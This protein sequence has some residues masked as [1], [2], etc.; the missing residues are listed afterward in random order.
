MRD[1]A[2]EGHVDVACCAFTFAAVLLE[3]GALTATFELGL[4]RRFGSAWSFV[5][6]GAVAVSVGIAEAI[7]A[8]EIQ[9]ASG[10]PFLGDGHVWT[11]GALLGIGTVNGLVGLG[12]WAIAVVFPFAVSDANARA[13][14]AER[15]RTTAELARLRAHLQPHFLLNTLNTV[16]GLVVEDP[17]EARN[18]V[19]AL[20]DLLR[21]SLEET[22]EM[23][24]IDDEVKWLR[25]YAE[26]LET[27]HRGVLT[28][29]WDIAEATRGV[30]VPRLLLQPLL[31]NA[32]QHGALRRREGGEVAMRTTIARDGRVT[33]VVE[34]NGP[35]PA[36]RATRPGALGIQLV[37]RRLALKYAGLATFR[38]ESEGGLTRS[39][40][41]IPEETPA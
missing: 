25:R 1:Y 4:R 37:T 34:D 36:A 5:L 2:H 40:V 38:L 15:L 27:R 12:L 19:G 32:V 9:R 28:F 7:A 14:E 22:D 26:I 23:Q 8:W 17:R 29:R 31:E 18:L 33:C 6:T 10:H 24:T 20:G 16:A 30:R 39:I 11:L 21:D 3:L 13:L 41:E 35:G